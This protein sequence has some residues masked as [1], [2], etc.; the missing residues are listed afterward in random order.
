MAHPSSSFSESLGESTNALVDALMELTPSRS[1]GEP[2]VNQPTPEF[3]PVEQEAPM[4]AQMDT[5][6]ASSGEPSVN[7]AAP[8]QQEVA[9]QALLTEIRGMIHQH[10]L[11]YIIRHSPWMRNSE[12]LF[13]PDIIRNVN[14]IMEELELELSSIADLE[15]FLQD[16]RANPQQLHT[17]FRKLWS[18]D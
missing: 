18:G 9:Q 11:E 13:G 5:T 16:I 10:Y 3:H 6:S 1:S 7:Q 14:S 15:Q 2:S 17:F 12:L 8:V 4:D